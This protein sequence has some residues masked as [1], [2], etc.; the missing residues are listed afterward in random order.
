MYAYRY[1]RDEHVSLWTYETIVF[2]TN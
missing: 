2:L 1:I